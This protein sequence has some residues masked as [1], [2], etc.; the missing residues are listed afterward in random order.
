MSDPRTHLI[1]H[2]YLPPAGF[3]A[4]Q[5]GVHKASTVLFPDVAAMRRREWKDKTVYT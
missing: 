3:E 5:P 2:P 4:P 1:H